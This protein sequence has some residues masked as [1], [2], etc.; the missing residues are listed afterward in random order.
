M[1]GDSVIYSPERL[2]IRWMMAEI[3]ELEISLDRYAVWILGGAHFREVDE[4]IA[5]ELTVLR[6][7]ISRFYRI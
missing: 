2:R 5:P 3:R 7:S 6:E 1:F 4:F